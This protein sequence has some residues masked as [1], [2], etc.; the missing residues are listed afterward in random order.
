MLN[1]GIKIHYG[2]TRDWP[3]RRLQFREPEDSQLLQLADVFSGAIAWHMNGHNAQPNASAAKTE[4]GN[5][6]LKKAGI[7]DVTKGT[8]RHGKFTIWHRQ[9]R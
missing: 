7:A 5:Y 1:R 8:A 9:L 6:I 2:D 3:F 4:L